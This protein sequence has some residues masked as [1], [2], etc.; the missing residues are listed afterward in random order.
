MEKNFKSKLNAAIP[1]GDK[2]TRTFPIKFKADVSETFVFDGQE[3]K[4][5]LSKDAIV[6]GLLLP[7]DSVIKRFGQNVVFF[8]DDKMTAQM[9]PVQIV[10]LLIIKLQLREKA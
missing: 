4:V 8:I 7:R 10:G 5:K 6:E 2:L 1:Q 9:I 3:A